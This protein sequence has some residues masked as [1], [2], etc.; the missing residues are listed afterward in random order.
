MVQDIDDVFGNDP[1]RAMLSAE[2]EYPIEELP[3]S[4]FEAVDDK[5]S[6]G[7]RDH[8]LGS[9]DEIMPALTEVDEE[10]ALT[11]EDSDLLDTETQAELNEKLDFFFGEAARK[12]YKATSAL[13]TA[14]TV[15]KAFDEIGRAHV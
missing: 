11:E 7:F 15:D 5:V 9:R 12:Q 6:D 10:A 1:K 4:A 8:H 14:A 2:E 13:A 3:A